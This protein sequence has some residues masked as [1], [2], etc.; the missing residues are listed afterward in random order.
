[1]SKLKLLTNSGEQEKL[2]K[3]ISS[4]PMSFHKLYLVTLTLSMYTTK[5]YDKFHLVF[6]WSRF[7]GSK[8]PLPIFY[9]QDSWDL[10]THSPARLG[11]LAAGPIGLQL[12]T[13]QFCIDFPCSVHIGLCRITGMKNMGPKMEDLSFNFDAEEGRWQVKKP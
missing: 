7:L 2:H 6:L 10:R 8:D 13:Y 4:L 9:G 3:W 12:I 1:M 5:L 11:A